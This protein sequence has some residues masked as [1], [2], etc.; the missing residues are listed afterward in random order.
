MNNFLTRSLSETPLQL[1]NKQMPN[2]LDIMSQR[3]R[4]SCIVYAFFLRLLIA[5]AKLRIFPYLGFFPS[6]CIKIEQ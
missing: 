2:K 3:H 1:S 4:A 6:D 5:T